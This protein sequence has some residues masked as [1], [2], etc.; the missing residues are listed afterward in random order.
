MYNKSNIMEENMSISI[1]CQC[2]RNMLIS[3]ELE[4]LPVRCPNCGRKHLVPNE[5]PI[6]IAQPVVEKTPEKVYAKPICDKCS[7]VIDLDSNYCPN[8][9]N[10]ISVMPTT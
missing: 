6:L 7:H 8:C 9:G 4:G 5:Q 3:E 2:G 10:N 1:K